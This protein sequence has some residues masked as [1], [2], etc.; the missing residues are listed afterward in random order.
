[1]TIGSILLGLGLLVVVA[2]FLARP[3][4]APEDKQRRTTR[5]EALLTQ[6]EVLLDQL[7]SLDFDRETGKIPEEVYQPQRVHLLAEAARLLAE[8]D[9]LEERQPSTPRPAAVDHLDEEIEAAIAGYRRRAQPRT[10]N[11]KG[12]FC[13][14]CGQ[15]TDRGDRYCTHCGH[16]L[17]AKQPA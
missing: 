1:M 15:P 2:L 12:G 4:M 11:G 10:S 13:S 17:S 14:H 3:F 6:K 5:R 8:I 9:A 16:K 7:Q